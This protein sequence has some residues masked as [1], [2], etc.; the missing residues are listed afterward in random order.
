MCNANYNFFG[1]TGQGAAKL[2]QPGS[3]SKTSEEILKIIDDCV[4]KQ[5]KGISDPEDN[6]TYYLRDRARLDG[7]L[8]IQAAA[9]GRPWPL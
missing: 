5:K 8:V 6:L 9:N 4:E 7:M 2:K 3:E 1:L